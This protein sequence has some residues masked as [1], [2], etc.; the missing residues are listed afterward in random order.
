MAVRQRQ[1]VLEKTY[2]HFKDFGLPLNIQQKDYMTIVGRN[3]CCVITVKRSFKAWKYLIHALKSNYPE[4]TAP[5]PK[6]KP[7]PKPVTPKAPKPTPKKA[8][9][10]PAVK[11]AVKKD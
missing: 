11:P 1:A 6:P 2:Q 3:A 7:E 10:K 8:A 9:V 5:K 4:L